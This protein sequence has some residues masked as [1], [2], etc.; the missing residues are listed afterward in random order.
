MIK[1][2]S[3]IFIILILSF[4]LTF[5]DTP[6]V[7]PE[8]EPC[9]GFICDPINYVGSSIVNGFLNLQEFTINLIFNFANPLTDSDGDGKLEVLAFGASIFIAFLQFLIIAFVLGWVLIGFQFFFTLFTNQSLDDVD[10]SIKKYFQL[11]AWTVVSCVITLVF[12][13]ILKSMNSALLSQT[14][15]YPTLENFR[16]SSAVLIIFLVVL[17]VFLI[18]QMALP[19]ILSFLVVYLAPILLPLGLIMS[20]M[21]NS[22]SFLGDTIVTLV[23]GFAI[24]PY[25]FAF[26]GIIVT[27]GNLGSNFSTDPDAQRQITITF[28]LL[29]GAILGWVYMSIMPILLGAKNLQKLPKLFKFAFNKKR[30]TM[31]FVGHRASKFLDKY[32]NGESKNPALRHMMKRIK[33]K[34]S[35]IDRKPL[36]GVG[37]MVS[38]P[39][40]KYGKKYGEMPAKVM[41][42]IIINPVRAKDHLYVGNMM[43][44]QKA[45]DS[46]DYTKQTAKD[47]YDYLK[48]TSKKEMYHHTKEFSKKTYK[49]TKEFTKDQI[50]KSIF[51][52]GNYKN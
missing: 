11:L 6:K 49:R 42:D 22:L 29:A 47:S 14:F 5:A 9:T 52:T 4:N 17:N 38:K 36:Y 16:W 28:V 12:L 25:I 19:M 30:G 8:P 51:G 41:A 37:A 21:D 15:L 40:I 13:S 20:K 27:N 1:R 50:R 46:Y 2:L 45:K 7:P 10:Y 3:L 26:I 18:F 24:F 48:N 31:P 44:K 35:E 23:K 34:A 33:S 32:P 39:T 43:A